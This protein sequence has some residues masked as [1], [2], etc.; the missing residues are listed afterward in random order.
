MTRTNHSIKRKTILQSSAVGI[1][2]GSDEGV[3]FGVLGPSLERDGEVDGS[4]SG[5]GIAFGIGLGRDEGKL[6][7]AELG[8]SLGPVEGKA[9]FVTVGTT[10][11][12]VDGDELGS[13]LGGMD[14]EEDGLLPGVGSTRNNSPSIV[15]TKIS[16]DELCPNVV[17]P[18]TI[19]RDVM[20]LEKDDPTPPLRAPQR[21]PVTKSA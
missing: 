5:V 18:T 15:A 12:I 20:S 2:L 11:G 7:G 19:P 14:G 10:L 21:F 3:L 6:L 9:L 17:A 1:G 8:P 4:V 16:P 13:R